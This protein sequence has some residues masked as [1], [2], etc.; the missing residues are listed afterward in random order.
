MPNWGG[1]DTTGDGHS[2]EVAINCDPTRRGDAN[3]KKKQQP[4]MWDQFFIF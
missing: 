3:N 2:D 4:T 1:G